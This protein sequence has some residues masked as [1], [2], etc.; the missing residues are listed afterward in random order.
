MQR[1]L[2]ESILARISA[3]LP[4]FKT[5]DLFND[6]FNNAD[7][8]LDNPVRFPALFVS[9]PE[10]AEYTN[11]GAGVQQSDD[12]IVRFHIGQEMTAERVGKTVLEVMDM[13]QRVY[14]VFQNYAA[15]FIKTFDRIREDPD[16]ARSN[17]YVFLQD[18][19]AGIIDSSKYVDQGAEVSLS[20]NITEQVIINP[21]TDGGIRTAKDVNDG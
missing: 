13:K 14:N 8:G 17:Y 15:P 16:E 2:I 1:V 10:G 7:Q 19:K 5:V 4:E 11:R 21:I 12:I 20:L 6:Q 9:F 18:Y 3:N